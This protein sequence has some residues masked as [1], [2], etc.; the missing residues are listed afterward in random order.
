M[1]EINDPK[2]KLSL[3]ENSY[4]AIR[5]EIN[6]ICTLTIPMTPQMNNAMAV[7]IEARKVPTTANMRIE[8]KF[9][10]KLLC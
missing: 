9:L 2:A 1:E 6:K 10:K 7:I 4:S 8:P 3:N 5:R